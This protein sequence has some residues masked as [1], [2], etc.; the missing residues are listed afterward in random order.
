MQAKDNCATVI[1][2]KPAVFM[3]SVKDGKCSIMA[4]AMGKKAS[5]VQI[6]N[7]ADLEPAILKLYAEMS[8]KTEL[9]FK[10][11]ERNAEYTLDAHDGVVQYV[12][13]PFHY[14]N[15]DKNEHGVAPQKQAQT[16]VQITCAELPLSPHLASKAKSIPQKTESN[17]VDFTSMVN[18]LHAQVATP[19]WQESTTTQQTFMLR[20]D[21]VT[22]IEKGQNGPILYMTAANGK[23]ITPIM[24][25]IP[26]GALE[27]TRDGNQIL[28]DCVNH[29]DNVLMKRLACQE[30][31]LQ[32]MR[33]MVAEK[34]WRDFSTA[35][36]V[37]YEILHK[38]GT[39]ASQGFEILDEN[40]VQHHISLVTKYLNEG[41]K[42]ERV[43]I[44]AYI[45][46]KPLHV[47]SL[48]AAGQS[49]VTGAA[50]PEGQPYS[51]QDFIDF[52]SKGVDAY[53][54]MPTQ[55]VPTTDENSTLDEESI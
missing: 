46:H 48:N 43:C 14:S 42:D 52:V 32:D 25:P 23:M 22:W 27:Y 13:Q 29:A 16:V 8:G 3:V 55:E 54:N 1:G 40:G 30:S 9:Q 20:H 4:C 24:I 7:P 53:Q 11:D 50:H 15:W 38:Q 33:Q 26:A 44:D 45:D 51:Y 6:E 17:G 2:V 10:D 49:I 28:R 41:Q 21:S 19:T 34:A 5:G 12:A 47:H 36:R 37:A 35:E 18:A 31:A 39:D